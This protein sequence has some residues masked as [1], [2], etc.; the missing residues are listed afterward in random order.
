MRTATKS[1]V[2]LDELGKFFTVTARRLEAGHTAPEMFSTAI[3]A[4]WHELADAP[5]AHAAFTTEHAGRELT[6]VETAG[7]GPIAWV[8]AYEEMY[9][10]LPEIW[11]T[12]A[13][14]TINERSLAFYR[15]TGTVVAE[16]DCSPTPSDGDMAPKAATR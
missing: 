10:P 6:H 8:T 3:D 15:K 4:V 9:G 14:G 5:Q 13:D 7:R 2:E 11:F 1:T 16:W 12:H